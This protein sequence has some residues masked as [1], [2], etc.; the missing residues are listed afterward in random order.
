MKTMSRGNLLRGVIFLSLFGA[1]F[2]GVVWLR[3]PQQPSSG[4][5][6]GE[7]EVGWEVVLVL[8]VDA[9]CGWSN[10]PELPVAWRQLVAATASTLP[11]SV[12]RVHTIGVASGRTPEEG[13]ALLSRL[14][15]F[16]EIV[17]GRRL[18][19]GVLRYMASDFRGPGSVPQV[20]VASRRFSRLEDGSLR[21]EFESVEQRYT[22]LMGIQT[23][24]ARRSALVGVH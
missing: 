1:G 10:D 19:S 2:L 15:P 21:R 22:G 18:N 24:A 13:I 4:L 14:G 17:A 8:I 12:G 9:A 7:P 6:V 20:V 11:D 3:A 23:A 5:L 16:D